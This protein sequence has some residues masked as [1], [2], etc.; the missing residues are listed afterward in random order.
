MSPV[1]YAVKLERKPPLRLPIHPDAPR[2]QSWRSWATQSTKPRAI[3]LFSGCG[4]LSLGLEQAGY[5]VVLSVDNDPWAVE[6]HRH[7]LPGSAVELDLSQ[8]GQI[9]S[10][11]SLLRGINI[12][13]VAGGPP[14][15]PFSRAGRSKIRSL[16]QQGTRNRRDERREFGLFYSESFY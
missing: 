6:S 14:C 8:S 15:Q 1:N 9:D 11:V 16:V 5:Q 4:G 12:D 3:D 13:L 2:T 7:N 10:L